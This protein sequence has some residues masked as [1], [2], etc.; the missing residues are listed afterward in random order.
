M[1]YSIGLQDLRLTPK[2]PK[3]ELLLFDKVAIPGLSRW[4]STWG[5]NPNFEA[6]VTDLEFLAEQNL[7]IEPPL[8]EDHASFVDSLWNDNFLCD[9]MPSWADDSL[10]ECINLITFTSEDVMHYGMDMAAYS[11]P[12]TL[13]AEQ[14][15]NSGNPRGLLKFFTTYLFKYQNMECVP[16]IDEPIF[17]HPL[18]DSYHRKN[19]VIR[20]ILQEVPMP[21]EITP[22]EQIIAFR[23][24]DDACRKLYALRIW[25]REMA[26]SQEAIQ[27]LADKLHYLVMEYKHYMKIQNMKFTSSTIESVLVSSVRIIE[28][29]AKFRLSKLLEDLFH[30]KN[31]KI[32]LLE[33]ELKAPGREIAYVAE[34]QRKFS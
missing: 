20:L 4:L 26:S 9:D 13:S 6:I 31:Q 28:D 24:D 33:A 2:V 25:M 5:Y 22:L 3:K 34:V 14:V 23:Q 29:I 32:A 18:G 19:D 21:S 1:Q 7:I 17:T 10:K 11:H 8:K 27:D 30:V 12:A 16:I 15:E